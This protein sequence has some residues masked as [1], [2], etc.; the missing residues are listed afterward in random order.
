MKSRPELLPPKAILEAGIVMAMN[1]TKHPDQKWKTLSDKDHVGAALRHIFTWLSGETLDHETGRSH[2]THGLC[3]MA[4]AVEREEVSCDSRS[5]RLATPMTP[6]IG[7]VVSI[8]WPLG[9][10]GVVVAISPENAFYK[11]SC[12]GPG[13]PYFAY[14]A[15]DEVKTISRP[16][17]EA[18]I[19]GK[20]QQRSP[21]NGKL[22][23]EY[24]EEDWN[25]TRL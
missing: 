14:F 21:K 8:P 1:E 17:Y 20:P 15:K 5:T 9:A 3:R 16:E 4:M 13:S 22:L 10:K 6:Q 24:T 23:D 11:V 18:Y 19:D 2:L 7:D 12:D 25:E